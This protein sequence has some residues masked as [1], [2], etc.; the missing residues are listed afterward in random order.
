MQM[1]E[2]VLQIQSKNDFFWHYKLQITI[3]V[4]SIFTVF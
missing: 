4:A 3:Y 2:S 1:R